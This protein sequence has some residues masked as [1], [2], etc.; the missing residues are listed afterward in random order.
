MT[1][2]IVAS[3]VALAFGFLA[4][5][6][7]ALSAT[8]CTILPGYS[9]DGNP[10][11]NC[12]ADVQHLMGRVKICRA[13]ESESPQTPLRRTEVKIG[14]IQYQCRFLQRD[15]RSI[16]LKYHPDREVSKALNEILAPL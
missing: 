11:I 4:F 14:L 15:A 2:F 8:A 9:Y 1:R 3:L 5:Q 12:P 13:L 6:A 16:Q 10:Y 7:S